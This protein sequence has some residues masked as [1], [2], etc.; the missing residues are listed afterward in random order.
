MFAKKKISMNASIKELETN[1]INEC[2]NKITQNKICLMLIDWISSL[3]L[4]SSTKN[5]IFN[6]LF[7]KQL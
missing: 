1:Y 7:E 4:L 2:I 6:W 5:I 3:S